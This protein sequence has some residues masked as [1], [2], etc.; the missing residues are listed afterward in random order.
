MVTVGVMD[1]NI[2]DVTPDGSM[3]T[4]LSLTSSR[5]I[6]SSHILITASAHS[7]TLDKQYPSASQAAFYVVRGIKY[8]R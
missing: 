6:V 7:A 8:N 1:L 4:F 3:L 2:I 5:D